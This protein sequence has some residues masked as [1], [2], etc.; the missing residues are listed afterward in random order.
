MI[1]IKIIYNTINSFYFSNI[2]T[3]LNLEEKC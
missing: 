1:Y 2:S 3:I